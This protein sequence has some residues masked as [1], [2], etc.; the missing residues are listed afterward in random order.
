[1]LDTN[2]DTVQAH[3]SR[4]QLSIAGSNFVFLVLWAWGLAGVSAP[5][6]V[7]VVIGKLPGDLV[8]R[9]ETIVYRVA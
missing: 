4:E 9:T 6:Q 3:S 2:D 1:M 5:L 8:G 7:Q